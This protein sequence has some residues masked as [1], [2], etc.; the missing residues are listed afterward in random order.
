MTEIYDTAEVSLPNDT[1]VVVKRSFKAPRA[2]VWRAYTEPA[3]LPRWMGGYPG[4]TMPV[5]EMDVRVG[6]KYQWRWH[7]DESGQEF[8]FY[9][10]FQE[11]DAPARLAHTEY[12][13]PG[14]MGGDMGKGALVS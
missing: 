6:G 12:F 1:D 5:C 11:V 10:E 3:L 7:N 4:W 8:G 13:D 14:T 9:G 2:L